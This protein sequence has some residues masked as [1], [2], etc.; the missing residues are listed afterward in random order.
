MLRMR[1]IQPLLGITLVMLFLQ[2]LGMQ[3][4]L[5]WELRLE[6]RRRVQLIL[7]ELLREE[8]LGMLILLILLGI[9]MLLLVL[10]K[11]GTL[12][13]I[14]LLQP[15]LVMTQGNAALGTEEAENPG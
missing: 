2:L 7:L 3:I 15:L 5:L 11:L 4:E 6:M 12:L 13:G 14:K 9:M 8:L 10:M 1:L